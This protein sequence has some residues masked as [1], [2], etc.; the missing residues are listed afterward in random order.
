MRE[1]HAPTLDEC[2]EAHVRIAPHVTATPLLRYDGDD[3]VVAIDLKL[4]NLQP[5]GSFKLRGALNRMLSMP[6]AELANGVYTAS[7]GNMAQG[8][9]Y[10]ARALGIPASVVVPETAPRAKLDAIVRL[11]AA[12]V[13]VPYDD[14]W[15]TMRD[16]GRAGMRGAFV[17][18]FADRDV[19]AGNGTVALE[20]LEAAP[21]C[22][23][24][25]VPWGGGGLAC[26]I[27]AAAK[28][29]RPQV[30]VFAC[31]MEG[32][33]P[34][35][36]SLAAGRPVSIENRRSFVDG[37]GGRGVLAE[38]WPLARELIAGALRVSEDDAAES[39]RL[40]ARR[41]RV[42]AEGAGAAA[43][44]AARAHVS[45]ITPQPKRVACIVS[46]GNIDTSVLAAILS[47]ATPP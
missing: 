41:A 6:P 4:E 5:I 2:R 33:A 29:I 3:P 36:A 20:L 34:L 32:A 44:A 7:A 14:W 42:I 27:A 8:V 1:L 40:M 39:V 17:H 45:S 22:D 15:T 23:V 38:M 46:G 11:G 24:I 25:L 21:D 35:S 12:I 28:A 37:I 16:H 30:R 19:M 31:E 18:P 13:Q 9:A 43:L 47:G 10:A 26:G